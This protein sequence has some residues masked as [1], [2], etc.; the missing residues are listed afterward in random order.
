MRAEQIATSRSHK[1]LIKSLARQKRASSWCMRVS[2]PSISLPRTRR[3]EKPSFNQSWGER[4]GRVFIAPLTNSSISRESKSTFMDSHRPTTFVFEARD[5]R[6][7]HFFS[8]FTFYESPWQEPTFYV[9]SHTIIHIYRKV[10]RT[11]ISKARISPMVQ[12][13]SKKC[14][15]F[16]EIT[17][18]SWN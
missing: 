14:F 5:T 7:R 6:L 17:S 1:P 3:I 12:N 13:P 11:I 9:R 2:C 8:G 15:K 16:F 18:Y 10:V 4:K